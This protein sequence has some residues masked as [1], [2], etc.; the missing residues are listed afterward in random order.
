MCHAWFVF[1]DIV[2]NGEGQKNIHAGFIYRL[3]KRS[4]NY[5]W[6]CNTPAK[7]SENVHFRMAVSAIW[8]TEIIPL[9]LQR[10][11]RLFMSGFNW[12]ASL[13]T[14]SWSMSSKTALSTQSITVHLKIKRRFV[15]FQIWLLSFNRLTVLLKAPLNVQFVV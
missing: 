12:A 2:H 15:F 7:L 4:N 14:T 1:R 11:W 6:T 10:L 9:K 5:Y 8:M 13:R 3:N